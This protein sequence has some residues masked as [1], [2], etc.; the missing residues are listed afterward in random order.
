MST[1]K[2]DSSSLVRIAVTDVSSELS[3]ESPLSASEI[4]QAT[5]DALSSNSPLLLTDIRGHQFVVPA[6][7][8]G[9]LEIGEPQERRVG[10]GVK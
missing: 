7:K 1:K 4:T 10:F 9:Y 6:S 2:R 8:I 3:F 5:T